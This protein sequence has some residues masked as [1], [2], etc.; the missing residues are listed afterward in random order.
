MSN[1]YLIKR[2]IYKIQTTESNELLEEAYRL[3]DL[4][5]ED[6]DEYKLS[7]NQRNAIAEAR[8]Q[9]KGGRFLADDLANKE[10]DEWL[11]Q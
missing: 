9:I 3:L 4:G 11:N 7:I 5:I 1:I 2:L 8:D 10:I 6:D